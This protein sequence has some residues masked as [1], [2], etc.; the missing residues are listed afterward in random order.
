MSE[1]IVKRENIQTIISMTPTSFEENRISCERCISAGEKLLASIHENGMN[2]ELDQAA[3]S[4]IEKS[5]KTVKKMNEKRSTVT[6]LFDSIKHEFTSLENSID[7]TKADT[8]GSK[9]QSLRNQYAAKKR[10][11]EEKRR[12]EEWLRQQEEQA[13]LKFEQ[14]VE[15]NMRLQFQ[16]A[17]NKAINDL[18]ALE[19][20]VTLQNYDD[21]CSKI[22]KASCRLNPEWIENLH[23]LTRIPSGISTE[24]V[25]KMEEKVRCKLKVPF[26]EQFETEMQDTRDF[27]LDRLPSKKANLERIAEANAEEAE[28][29]KKELAEKQK[30]QMLKQEEERKR[31]EEEEKMR[32]EV[33]QQQ[34]E[35]NTLF[36]QTASQVDTYQPKVKVTQKISLLNP[37]GILPIISMWWSKLGCT[38]TVEEIS[39]MFKKQIKFCEDLANKEDIYI[40]DESVE[41][42]EEVKAK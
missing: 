32:K 22:S 29:L 12:R 2:D 5:R 40:K 33:E 42:K 37:E 7:P 28:R 14:D 35:M 38:L 16:A 21:V 3:A 30:Q 9:L 23:S 18:S 26:K 19:E 15:D 36:N 31:R 27:I 41:Y 1:E 20:E 24:E 11:E 8:I 13:R 10:E 34:E 25:K 17:L 39:K 4:F 6:K